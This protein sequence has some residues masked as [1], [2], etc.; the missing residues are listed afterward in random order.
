MSKALYIL[1]SSK[2]FLTQKALKSVYYALFHSNLIYSIPIWSCASNSS[3]KSIQIL[4]KKAIRIVH[5]AKYNSH[6]EPLFKDLKILPLNSL[7]KFFNLQFIQN[8]MQGFLPSSFNR[9]WLTN[10]ERRQDEDDHHQRI[11]RNNDQLHIPFLRLN[12]LLKFPLTNLPR[13]WLEFTNENIKILRNKIEFKFELKKHLL[14]ELSAVVI[15]NRLLC[16][17]CHLNV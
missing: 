8:Y 7:I 14:N 10:E 5:G 12:S 2:N 17:S 3:L 16:P 13:T 15:C 4:Q 11:L 6:S 1:R 9:I